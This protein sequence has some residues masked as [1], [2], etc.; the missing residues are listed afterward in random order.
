[1]TSLS[2]EVKELFEP[3]SELHK[4]R[5]QAA[6]LLNNDEWASYKKVTAALNQERSATRRSFE[7]SFEGRVAK[8]SQRLINEAGAVKRRFVPR[9]LG[10]DG[11][12]P[13][14]IRRQAKLEVNA[15]HKTEMAKIDKRETEATRLCVDKALQ[16]GQQ[17]EKLIGDFQ[18]ATDRRVGQERRTRSWSR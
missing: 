11:F 13:D 17:R 6:E 5:I 14:Q 12:N 16:R 10:S 18:T 7:E 8:T 1:M 3:R 15:A 4:L 2:E 9:G